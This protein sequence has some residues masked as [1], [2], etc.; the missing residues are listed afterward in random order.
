[1]ENAVME[2]RTKVVADGTEGN[3]A[4][5]ANNK[6]DPKIGSKLFVAATFAPLE[7]KEVV[8]LG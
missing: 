1:M 4:D 3:S 7:G 2:S 6:D 5:D 8:K